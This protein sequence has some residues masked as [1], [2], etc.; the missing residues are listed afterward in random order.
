MINKF[1][2]LIVGILGLL[3]TFAGFGL[4][5]LAQNFLLYLGLALLL[6]ALFFFFRG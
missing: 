4:I 5:T 3:L 1:F 2:A 6:L